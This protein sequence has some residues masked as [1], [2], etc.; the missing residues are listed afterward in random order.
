MEPTTQPTDFKSF[1]RS[2]T[3]EQKKSFAEQAGTTPRYIE[4]HLVYA[5]KVPGPNLMERLYNAC[6]EFGASF[7]K[8]ELIEFFY[9][10]NKDRE[11][12]S[13]I[14][15]R[16]AASDDAQPPSGT[17]DRKVKESRMST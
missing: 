6:V 4:T 5:S 15:E 2:L 7:T 10:P 13:S 12:K 1:Y 9:E 17:A 8:T 16:N 3:S 11:R 14:A